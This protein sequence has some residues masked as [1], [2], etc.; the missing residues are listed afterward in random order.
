MLLLYC[1]K[2][3]YHQKMRENLRYNLYLYKGLKMKI[4]DLMLED[5]SFEDLI[6]MQNAVNK[7]VISK[8]NNG[9][10]DLIRE[11][12]KLKIQENNLQEKIKKQKD[13]FRDLLLE[14]KFLKSIENCYYF[15]N[16]EGLLYIY[17]Y[18]NKV[19]IKSL[20]FNFENMEIVKNDG[21]TEEEIVLILKEIDLII[22]NK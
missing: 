6:V 21:F 9:L 19:T 20:D 5:M 22:N 3:M 8:R 11:I 17:I 14:N 4:Q 1:L 13:F 12:K 10:G 7:K 18:I 2:G 16:H 15:V